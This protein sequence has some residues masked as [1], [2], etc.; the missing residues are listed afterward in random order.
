MDDLVADLP[1]ASEWTFSSGCIIDDFVIPLNEYSIATPADLVTFDVAV[2]SS[3]LERALPQVE[4]SIGLARDVD[5]STLVQAQM[6]AHKKP[7]AA[8][9]RLESHLSSSD[10]LPPLL[11][12]FAVELYRYHKPAIHTQVTDRIQRQY[13]NL[14][15]FTHALV[16]G[17][18]DMLDRVA[19]KWPQMT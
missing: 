5:P 1:H 19:R 15:S 11:A 12:A 7:D 10:L 9:S 6:L 4:G 8:L 13:D 14:C 2:H 3:K 16:L 18:D 17:D